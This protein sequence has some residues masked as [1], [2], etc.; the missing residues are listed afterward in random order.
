MDFRRKFSIVNEYSQVTDRKSVLN[1]RFLCGFARKETFA[2]YAALFGGAGGLIFGY[3][4]GVVSG[5]LPKLKLDFHLTTIQE[6][7]VVSYMVIGC[8]IGAAI[9]GYICDK[10][11]RSRTFCVVIVH[12]LVGALLLSYAQSVTTIYIGRVIVGIGVSISAIV[13]VAYL[14]EISPIEYR[15]TIVSSNELMITVGLLVA[16]SAGYGFMDMIEGWRYM[17][18]LPVPIV[19]IWGVA[20][21]VMP[22]SPRWLLVKGRKEEAMTILKGMLDSDE[23]AHAAYTQAV[24]EIEKA[25]HGSYQILFTRWML[26]V[27]ISVLIMLLQQF[28]GHACVLAYAPEIFASVGMTKNAA[29]LATIVI[30]VTKVFMT[31]CTL[32]IVDHVGRRMLLITGISGMVISLAVLGMTSYIEIQNKSKDFGGDSDSPDLAAY[33][34]LIAVCTYVASYAI[35]FGPISWLVVSEM[36]TDELRGR[37]LGL[38][39]VANW[40]GNFLVAVTFLDLVESLR[41]WGTFFFYMVICFISLVLVYFI[42][43]ETCRKEPRAILIDLHRRLGIEIP[44]SISQA[45]PTIQ[46]TV[47]GVG[48]AGEISHESDISIGEGIELEMSTISHNDYQDT[49][50]SSS[51][52]NTPIRG[53]YQGLTCNECIAKE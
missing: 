53:L 22:E 30:G 47:T 25:G 48:L 4:L 8:L 52:L 3:D 26:P 34:S 5:A 39:T 2:L 49:N 27:G 7:L 1:F 29:G 36:F 37:A 41:I 16:F 32:T 35:G 33:L 6:E 28:S 14:T 13:D 21:C 18:L 24:E 12:F 50:T 9:G 15:G 23:D 20:A 11:G 40:L 46:H 19:L 44:H 10:I 45:F 51:D 43:P 38:A 17:F 42:L 31:A